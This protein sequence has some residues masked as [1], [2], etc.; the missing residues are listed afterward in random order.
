MLALYATSATPRVGDWYIGSAWIR[1]NTTNGFY[2]GSG[3]V[4]IQFDGGVMAGR[5]INGGRSYCKP[6]WTGGEEWMWCY[7][8]GKIVTTGA[9][10]T[11]FSLQADGTHSTSIYCPT[12]THLPSGTIPDNEV[13][14]YAQ[15]LQPFAAVC[16]VGTTCN[17]AGHSF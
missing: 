2:Y 12:F 13:W 6:N 16:S 11:Q 17:C 10:K 3:P 5:N 7:T 9:G 8:L 14:E 4:F 1:A 15:S